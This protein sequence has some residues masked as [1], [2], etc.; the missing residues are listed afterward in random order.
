MFLSRAKTTNPTS[1]N[2]DQLGVR[3]F[4]DA[5]TLGIAAAV[6][7]AQIISDAIADRGVARVMVATGNSQLEVIKALV[8]HHEVDWGKV[9]GFHLDEYVGISADHPASF[10]LWIRT[11]FAEKVR[12]GEMNYIEGDLPDPDGVAQRYASYLARTPMDLAFVGIG[13]NGHIAFNDPAVADFNDP[14][15]VKRV[16]LDTICR[17]QQVGEGHFRT[18]DDVPREALTVSCRGLLQAKHWICCVPERRK[19]R[20]VRDSLEGP[21]STVCPGSVARRHPHAVLYLDKESSSLLSP[22]AVTV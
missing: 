9:R 3:I 16:T 18:T 1:F 2:V 7:A 4:T 6:D 22:R 20:A 8:E 19:A 11:R 5:R 13:E 17:A 10:R 15:L 21:I 12:P 14:L